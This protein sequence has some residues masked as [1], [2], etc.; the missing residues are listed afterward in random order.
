MIEIDLQQYKEALKISKKENKTYIFD[1]IRKKDIL[2]QP[3]ELVRQLFIQYLLQ[4]RAYSKKLIKVE[5]SLTVNGQIKRFDLV[6][7]NNKAEPKILVECKRPEEK[8][9]QSVFNQVSTYNLVLHADYLVV[10]NGMSTFCCSMDY[11]KNTFVFQDD[12]PDKS[13]LI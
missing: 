10:T 4:E 5:K 11:D 13:A 1:P 9:K 12:I 7:Y 6:I 3:E 2:L 8:I